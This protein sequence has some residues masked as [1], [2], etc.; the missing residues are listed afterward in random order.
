VIYFDTSYIVRLYMEDP[1]S[2][3]VRETAATDHVACC[4]LG[5]AETVAAFH[6]CDGVT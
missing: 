1:G 4:L 5:H 6:R 2:Q 3:K